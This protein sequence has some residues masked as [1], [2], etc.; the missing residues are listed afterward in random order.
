MESQTRK[1]RGLMTWTVTDRL[2]KEGDFMI[3][4]DGQPIVFVRPSEVIRQRDGI[5][6]ENKAHYVASLIHSFLNGEPIV[7]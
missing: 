6:A 3:S 2:R 5:I 4:K 1:G 7:R